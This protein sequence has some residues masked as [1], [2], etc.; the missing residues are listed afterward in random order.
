MPRQWRSLPLNN[1]TGSEVFDALFRRHHVIATLLETPSPTEQSQLARYSICAGSPRIINGQQQLWTPSLGQI[2]PFLKR[3]LRRGTGAEGQRSRGAEEQRKINLQP[4]I[5]HL[6]FTGGWLGWLGYDLAWEIE[7]LP[8]LKDDSLPFPIAYWYE[9]A[10]FAVLDHLEQTLWLAATQTIELDQLQNQLDSSLGTRNSELGTP[11]PSP[12]PSSPPKPITKTRCG[13]P[14]STFMLAIFFKR[15]SPCAF[16][17]RQLL[18]VGRFI[19]PCK[20]L[21]LPLSPVF[22]K[23]LGER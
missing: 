15:I 8:R 19:V 23:L 22:G 10:T 18:I 5:D 21:I 2:L 7:Q 1:R 12:P 13:K 6:P 11:H 16:R 14:K 3:L 20:R 9:P 4:P 17:S